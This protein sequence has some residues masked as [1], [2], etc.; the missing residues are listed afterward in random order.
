MH[1]DI[2][3]CAIHKN[4][5]KNFYNKILQKHKNYLL[6]NRTNDNSNDENSIKDERFL[7][8]L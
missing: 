1:I 2:T 4:R 3:I 6:I 7:K 8:N 5:S